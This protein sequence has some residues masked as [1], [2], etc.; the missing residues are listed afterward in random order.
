[1]PVLLFASGNLHKLD[2]V[3]GLLG[4]EFEVLGLESLPG[5][6]SPEETGA[7]FEENAK[8]KAEAASL[9]FD[10]YVIADDSGLEVDALGGRPGVRSA[11]FAGEAASDS[12]NNCLLLKE[13]DGVRGKQ[14]SA[15]FRCVLAV[16][17]AGRTLAVFDGAVEGILAN[18]PK[19]ENGFGYDPLFIPEGYCETFAS[20]GSEVKNTFSHRARAFSKARPWLM[21]CCK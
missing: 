10:G 3:R 8:I 1:M 14:R 20:L 12:E 5:Y 11:R 13:L 18:Q 4:A 9:C 7:T 19:G 21:Q 2:E 17:S 15:R 6:T 16:A